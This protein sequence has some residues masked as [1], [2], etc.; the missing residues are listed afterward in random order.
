MKKLCVL[1]LSVLFF[2]GCYK[3]DIDRLYSEQTKLEAMILELQERC[4]Q[5]NKTVELLQTLINGSMIKETRPFED[6]ETGASGWE[7]VF[8]DNT[9]FRV[10]NGKDGETPVISVVQEN[11]E[12]YW[13]LNGEKL[14]DAAGNPLRMNGKDGITPTIN[15]DGYWVIDGVVTNIK[16]S[17][18]TPTV[19]IN[20]DGYWVING[21]VTAIKA[22]VTEPA[23]KIGADLIDN[24]V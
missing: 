3:E 5:I 1:L 23:L 15:A 21:E 17:G 2:A 7:I 14:T 11:E 9:S 10:Y 24:A 20:A 8:T 13:T 19:E 4:E 22:S 18:S 16:A 6:A 12:W